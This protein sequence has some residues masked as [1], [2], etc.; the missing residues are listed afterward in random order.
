LFLF[1]FFLEFMLFLSRSLICMFVGSDVM[2]LLCGLE[3]NG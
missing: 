3:D 1:L 2:P